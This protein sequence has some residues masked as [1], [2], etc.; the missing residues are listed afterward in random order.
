M[1]ISSISQTKVARNRKWGSENPS[2]THWPLVGQHPVEGEVTN[3]MYTGNSHINQKAS[4]SSEVLGS[5]P[6]VA[7]QYSL[8]AIYNVVSHTTTKDD[9]M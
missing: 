1:V 9:V 6:F 7:R 3:Y 4:P 8:E 2:S 5:K